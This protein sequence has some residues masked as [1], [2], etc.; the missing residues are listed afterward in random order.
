MKQRVGSLKDKI[1][2]PSTK[3][4]KEGRTTPKLMKVEMRKGILKQIP[5]KF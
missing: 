5:M 4:T 3:L 2:K 1:D